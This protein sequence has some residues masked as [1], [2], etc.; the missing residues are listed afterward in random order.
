MKMSLGTHVIPHSIQISDLLCLPLSTAFLLTLCTSLLFLLP[1]HSN[2]VLNHLDGDDWQ[3]M[4]FLLKR[5]MAVHGNFLFVS[6]T[7]FK[8]TLIINSWQN[9]KIHWM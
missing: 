2:V 7:Y 6:T 4:L 3:L 9:S 8:N 5:N 1:A